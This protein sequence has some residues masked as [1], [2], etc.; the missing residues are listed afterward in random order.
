MVRRVLVPKRGE[1]VKPQAR[2]LQ[3]LDIDED[4]D[5]GLG[6]QTWNRRATH[7]VDAAYDPIAECSN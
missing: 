3:V 6:R 2:L 5:G 1:A 7:V 4:V